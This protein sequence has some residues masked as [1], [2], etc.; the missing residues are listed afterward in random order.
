MN[1]VKRFLVGGA[2]DE[3]ITSE[4]IRAS[5]LPALDS[6]TGLWAPASSSSSLAESTEVVTQGLRRVA[7]DS[8]AIAKNGGL[9]IILFFQTGWL[10]HWVWSF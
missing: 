8:G 5:L 2:R 3:I 6:L 7:Q 9:N 10:T 1:F 4:K